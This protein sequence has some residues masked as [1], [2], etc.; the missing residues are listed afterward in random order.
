MDLSG[1]IAG[2]SA[3]HDRVIK[4]GTGD[5]DLNVEMSDEQEEDQE[6]E[7]MDETGSAEGLNG[8][9][10][11]IGED[12]EGWL[13]I[14]FQVPGTRLYLLHS[15]REGVIT[16]WDMGRSEEECSRAAESLA[17]LGYSC[18]EDTW[19]RPRK[20][21]PVSGPLKA[22]TRIVDVSPGR[23]EPQAYLMGLLLYEAA[24]A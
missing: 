19:N 13:D 18:G 14:I 4:I 23:E 2:Q 16:V 9:P 8:A 21:G 24:Q 1:G 11:V 6:E 20:A 10:G 15:R 22:A 5:G 7:E 3:G 12:G 17:S